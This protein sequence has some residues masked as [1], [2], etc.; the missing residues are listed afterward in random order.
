[1]RLNSASSLLLLLKLSHLVIAA[2]LADGAEFAFNG[3]S[4]ANLSLDG[5]A[6]V[7]PGGL[8]ML[9]NGS[10]VM[11]GHAFYP[12]PLHLHG[13]RKGSTAVLIYGVLRRREQPGHGILHLPEQE[14]IN[15]LAW[16]LPGPRQRRRQRQREQPPLRRRARHRTK[17]GVPGHR[18]QPINH[19]GVD[20]NSLTSVKAAT[21]GYYNDDM[22]F[23]RNLSLISRNA[24]QVWIDY[25]GLT[26]ELNVT[27]A[28]VEITKP[29]KPLLS[30]IVNFS[31]VCQQWNICL[32]G[33]TTEGR[34]SWVSRAY[35]STP[36][37]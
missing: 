9:T 2:A 3:F 27:M 21:A 4:A 25:D 23:F 22:S 19:V 14:I 36:Q 13:S 1:M 18:R 10:T 35:D 24:M 12:S 7:A 30:T 11:K 33:L 20:I 32:A 31:A 5:M 34:C 28:P 29:K 15:G 6:A 16:S 26:M 37:A 17:Q 8:L